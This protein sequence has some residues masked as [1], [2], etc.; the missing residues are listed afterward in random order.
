MFE[1]LPR[2]ERDAL[3]LA[4]VG[5]AQFE[6]QADRTGG[7]HVRLAE[8]FRRHQFSLAPQAAAAAPAAF[9]G[10][11][12]VAAFAVVVVIVVDHVPVVDDQAPRSF[13]PDVDRAGGQ[14][15]LLPRL[16][17]LAIHPMGYAVVLPREI[18]E[19]LAHEAAVDAK[20]LLPV[21]ARLAGAQF[22]RA[23]AF[24]REI[25]LE[26]EALR[27]VDVDRQQSLI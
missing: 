21:L 19:A 2:V 12:E 27:T 14:R 17:R 26:Y 9:S 3:G 16:Q 8:V 25:S 4:D 24:G 15:L 6:D 11:I 18:V 23:L 22:E 10:R 5:I 7:Q 20:V 13:E 1:V